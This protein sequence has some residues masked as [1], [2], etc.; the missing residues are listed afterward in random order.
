MDA[1]G[2]TEEK[3][4]DEDGDKRKRADAVGLGVKGSGGARVEEELYA[5]R[6]R[7]GGLPGRAAVQGCFARVPYQAELMTDHGPATTMDHPMD[8]F[9][10]AHSSRRRLPPPLVSSYP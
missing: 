4:I 5:M 9:S 3:R 7:G 6:S 2:E 8:R 1:E 10:M